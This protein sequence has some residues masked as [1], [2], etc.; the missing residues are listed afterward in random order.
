[1]ERGARRGGREAGERCF[2]HLF[3]EKKATYQILSKQTTQCCQYIHKTV[4]PSALI[5]ECFHHPPKK[6]P[7]PSSRHR[8]TPGIG[9]LWP[10]GAHPGISRARN[11]EVERGDRRLPLGARLSR[12]FRDVTRF[13]DSFIVTAHSSG[14]FGRRSRHADHV[15]LSLRGRCGPA[16]PGGAG[17]SV[18]TRLGSPVRRPSS[19]EVAPNDRL[20]SPWEPSSLRE[21]KKK[22]AV[23]SPPLAS[24]SAIGTSRR[25]CEGHVPALSQPLTRGCGEDPIGQPGSRARCVTGAKRM[26]SAPSLPGF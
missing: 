6:T 15:G 9:L 19:D 26:G 11:R 25:L 17:R 20:P 10:R 8:W 3:F 16:H 12:L 14:D 13:A 23:K 4:P 1:M 21:K 24:R 18:P 7:I 5:P 2:R 22:K